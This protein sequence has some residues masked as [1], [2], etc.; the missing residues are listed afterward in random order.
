MLN[1]SIIIAT[2]NSEKTLTLALKSIKKQTYSQ[3]QIEILVI[4]GGSTD[5]TL[6]IAKRYNCRI[7]PNP[8]KE[9][10]SAK[11]LGVLH[12]KGKYAMFLD[13]DEVIENPK[14]LTTRLAAFSHDSQIKAVIGSGYKSPSGY[15]FINKYINE[16]GDPFSFFIYRL[17][18]DNHFFIPTMQKKYPVVDTTKNYIIFDLSHEKVLPIIE[19][20]AMGSMV[21]LQYLKRAFPKI[22]KQ[23]SLI[24]HFFY[25]INNDNKYIA[26]TK[27][28]ALYHYSS[29]G[30]NKYLGKITWRIKNN[31]HHIATLGASAYTGREKFQPFF[32]Q[33]KK[34]LFI[35]YSL[36]V[37][38]AFVD[39]LWLSVTRKNFSYMLHVGLCFYTTIVIIQQYCLK[40]VGI[41]PQLRSYGDR[42]IVDLK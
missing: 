22:K 36:F 30:L 11:H 4:D 5:K 42:D 25:L 8:R 26:L 16:F 3:A 28:D 33:L 7:I 10:I 40:I 21:D 39:A 37:V 34:Y 41:K 6:Q 24:P 35:P 1:I 14:S 27:N 9:P 15:P 2:Y 18:K 17:S 38:P 19:L 12:A 23:P 29:E 31:I 20:I 32:V 13:S